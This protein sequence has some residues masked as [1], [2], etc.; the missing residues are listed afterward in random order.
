MKSF[1]QK[2]LNNIVVN[3]FKYKSHAKTIFHLRQR[4][5][6]PWC[7]AWLFCKC[8]QHFIIFEI[9]VTEGTMF[10]FFF[11][12]FKKAVYSSLEWFFH[13]SSWLSL[14]ADSP[15]SIPVLSFIC[16]V[17]YSSLNAQDKAS[18]AIWKDFLDF[19]CHVCPA[20]TPLSA[21]TFIFLH[22]Q[23]RVHSQAEI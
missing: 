10:A 17:K 1:Q 13:F 7:S 14:L 6:H 16:L 4:I 2:F 11:F 15:F 21:R 9:T 23:L 5:L 3:H 19:L 22:L 12:F 20:P 18:R 8:I